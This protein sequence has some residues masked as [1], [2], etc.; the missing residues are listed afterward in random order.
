[1]RKNIPHTQRVKS[2]TCIRI[3]V[4]VYCYC[5]ASFNKNLLT[6]HRFVI[7]KLYNLHVLEQYNNIFHFFL[8]TRTINLCYEENFVEYFLTSIHVY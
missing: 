2:G 7:S 4:C 3:C 1:M 5:G 8:R 6:L